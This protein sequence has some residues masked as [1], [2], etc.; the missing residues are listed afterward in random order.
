[1]QPRQQ[2]YLNCDVFLDLDR[3]KLINDTFGHSFGDVLLQQVSVRLRECLRE[4][5]MVSRYGGDEYII[6]LKQQDIQEIYGLADQ[7][8]D[9]VAAPFY[10]LRPRA[11]YFT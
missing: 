1:M 5:D 7:I 4:D 10:D 9:T 3:F 2:T 8:I 6:V 11:I